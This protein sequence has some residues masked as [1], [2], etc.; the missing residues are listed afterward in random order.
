MLTYAFNVLNEKEYRKLSTEEFENINELFAEI[1]IISLNKQIKQGL[2]KDYIPKTEELSTIRG[3]I[4]LTNS[5]STFITHRQ[6][7]CQYDDFSLNNYKNQIIKTTIHY[8]LRENISQKKKLRKIIVYFNNVD[9]LDIKRINWKLNYDRNNQT[10]KMII[11]IC[12]MTIKGLLQNKEE[13]N[14]KLA[15]YDEDS[16]S[17]LYEKF[18]LKYYKKEHPQLKTNAS[19]IKWQ[20]DD[21]Y[22]TKLPIMKTDITLENEDNILIIDAK[23]YTQTMQENYNTKKLH[24]GNLYQIF[25]Y[26][27]NKDVE[28]NQ[29]KVVSGMLLYAKTTEEE[30]PEYTYHMS[31]NKISAKTLDLNVDFNN[32]RK[33]LDKI[34]EEHF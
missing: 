17:K 28:I 19:Q 20:L 14:I 6:V 8:L 12:Y 16:M 7:T 2:R 21:E 3:K 27:K 32:I 15:D 18:I 22:N 1:L 26:V 10:Y 24:S 9:L 23:Y 33:Q 13:K 30:Y 4:N 34:V 5:I 11:T 29:E 25:T 31:G